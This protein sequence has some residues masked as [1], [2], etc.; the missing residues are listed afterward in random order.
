MVDPAASR[1]LDGLQDVTIQDGM[2]VSV[3][4]NSQ[5]SKAKPADEPTIVDLAGKY[6]CP[7]VPSI[8]SIEYVLTI[9]AGV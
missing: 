3:T 8:V 5:G 9:S 7:Y 6:V 4:P 1:L 2:V